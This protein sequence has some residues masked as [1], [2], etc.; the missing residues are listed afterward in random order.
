MKRLALLLAALPLPAMA[1]PQQAD[2][3]FVNGKVLTVD[4]D[5]AI[6]TAI[7]IKDGK[8]AAT[9]GPELAKDWQAPRTVDLQGRTLMPGFID[10]HLHLK[11][12]SHRSIEPDK[13][14]SI[15]ELGAMVAAKARELGPGEWVAGSGWDEA[16]LAEKRN[17]SRADLDAIAPNNPV[18]LVRAGAHSAVANSLALKLAGIDAN[19]PNPAGGVIERGPDGQPSGIIR[20][21][22][23][24]V[25]KL[26]PADSPAQMRPSYVNSLK[27]L[28]RLGITSFMEAW[29]TI[30]D[31]PVEQGGISGG[32][33][34]AVRGHT[35]KQLSAIYAEEGESLPRA[36]L[37]IMYP[38]AERLK[39]FPHHTG[40]GDDRLKLGPIGE[41]AYDGGF[42]GPT[43]RTSKDY[44]GQPGFR[45]TTFMTEPALKDMI[46][47]SAALGWQLGIHAIGDEAINIVAAA[48]HE[49]LVAHPKQ[50]H[51]WFISHFTMMPT[52]QT[53]KT[54]AA[55]GVWTTAQPNFTYN[56]EGRYLQVLDGER[57]DTINPMATPIGLG[58]N[59]VMSSDNLPIG[60][61]VG[62]YSAVT[63]KGMTGHQFALS[64]AI[65]REQAIRLYTAKAA[66]VAWDEA[67]KGTL[68]PG[69]FADFIV[70]DRDPLTV[71]A[72]QLLQTLVDQTWVGGKLVY[73][74]KR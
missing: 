69:K 25:L 45:G 63:R 47:T 37:Y 17:P 14:R 8:I 6:H 50:D 21:R 72:E 27:D 60:P 3:L 59:V 64:E 65:T 22:T 52:Q 23:D 73:S 26:V 29:T 58:V 5:F 11:G 67:K 55:D 2:V 15:A 43:A 46:D 62:L 53:M 70:L 51:R 30:D 36:T 57:L 68:E 38:G 32:G 41:S 56:L 48:Y 12:L 39:K 31:E 54:M 42:T 61:M 20:E 24:L 7:A 10:T 18:V 40:Y 4:K 74:R 49:N 66:A 71:P 1:A 9:G 44:K 28:L 33:G 35:F 16:L 34:N 19:T 13:A